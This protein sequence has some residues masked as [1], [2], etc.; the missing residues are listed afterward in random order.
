MP[1]AVTRLRRSDV[2]AP[3]IARRRQGRGFSYLDEEGQRVADAE[4]LARVA[5]L[6]IPPAWEEVWICPYP[7]GHIQATGIDQKGRKQYLYHPR[8]RE[9]RDQQKFDDMVE[10][11]RRLPQL[12]KRAAS[13][14][15]RGDM[16]AA[17]VLACAVRLLDRGFF[18]IGSES[19]A[20]QNASYGLATMKKRHCRLD[21]DILRFDFPAKSG[22]RRLQVVVDPEVAGAVARHAA[23]AATSC[24]PTSAAGAGPTSSR[25][26]STPT[27]RTQPGMTS[28]RRTSGPGARPFSQRWRSP[29]QA[30]PTARRPPASARSRVR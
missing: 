9:R 7:G 22:K 30:R 13:D 16:S 21:G 10:F 17:H 6:V 14:L 25:P 12:R 5:E 24:W 23:A 20:E 11:A 15:A 28:P 1:A 26:T 29:C 19:Y 27:S 4:V 8:W 3:G 18:R 2:R